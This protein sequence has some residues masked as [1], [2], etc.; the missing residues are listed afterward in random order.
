MFKS[1]LKQN[2]RAVVCLILVAVIFFCFV[3]RLF[4]WQ[5]IQGSHYR[6][7]VSTTA[8]YRLYSE[9]T[10]GEIVDVNGVALKTNNTL[11][12]VTINKLY[13]SED[14]SVNEVVE[15]LIKL[16]EKVGEEWIDLL[17]IE[18]KA[19]GT[20]EFK[21]P[22][23]TE[24]Q[25]AMSFLRS[26]DFLSLSVYADANEYMKE[27]LE[28]YELEEIEDKELSRNICSVRFNME[29]NLFTSTNPYTFAEKVSQELT[30]IVAEYSQ[31][32]PSVEIQPVSERICLDGTLL[33]HILG[34]TGPLTAEEYEEYGDKGYSYDDIIGKF[35]IEYAMES[36]LKG[37]GGVKTVSKDETGSIIN[38]ESVT[39]AKPGN[40]VYLTIDS[41]LQKV[42][43]KSLAENVQAAQ[44]QGMKLS[45]Q[46]SEEGYGEDC[47]AGAVVALDVKTFGVLT[48]ASYPSYDINKYN[49]NDYYVSLL[50]DEKLP[51]F[52]RA[53]QGAF[54]PGSVVKPAVALAALE[55]GTISEVTSINCTKTYDYYPSNV[56]NCMF[57]HGVL[58]V[59]EAITKSCNYYFAE[60]GRRLGIDTM[61]LYMEKLG[62]GEKTGLEIAESGGFL[63]GRDSSNWVPGNT[64]QAAIGQSDN[65][66]TPVQLATYCATIAN[67]G[68]RLKTHLV[69]KVTSYDRT[70]TILENNEKNAEVVEDL[71]LT[72]YNLKVVQNAMR[73]VAS[74]DS[75]TAYYSF[76]DFPIEIGAK[77]G[78]AENIG[79]DHTTFI[80]YAPF[81]DPEIAVAVVLEHGASGT[82]SMAVAK[83]IL[84]AY[85]GLDVEETTVGIEEVTVSTTAE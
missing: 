8:N 50:E 1:F 3:I 39:P 44:A 81:D 16:F 9:A 4:D 73:N 15:K 10:R 2:I 49:D 12:T 65:T 33:P 24:E 60:V 63:A 64:V 48:A 25:K 75:G 19:D 20:Y 47:I 72:P 70:K 43:N 32:L 69:S 23:T 68:V 30:A 13:I 78:T 57:Y 14:T 56:V 31:A 83:D 17:P 77:T 84:N 37:E 6:E 51:L 34:T 41:N 85:F 82:F 74:S 54:A 80:C 53:F 29:R 38:V 59:T 76:L 61:W 58:G 45:A 55:E 28:R 62:L 27:L 79:S 5:I 21:E 36:Y 71:N 67:N 18:L 52:D 7:D 42:A 40:T 22:D 35:G 66:F 46:A 11:Y 26:E